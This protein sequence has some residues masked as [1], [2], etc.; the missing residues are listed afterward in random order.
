MNYRVLEWDSRFFDKRVAQITVAGDDDVHRLAECLEDSDAE[1]IYV[2]LP[3]ETAERYRSV[4]EACSGTFYD[5]KVRFGKPVDPALA[6]WDP[7]L[8]E[9]TAESEDL[10]RL[11]YACGYL[12][13]FCLDPGFKP[14]FE[15]L[16]AEW[17]RKS[18]RA[19][20]SRV[21]TL[22]DSRRML[23]MVVTSVKDAIGTMELLAIDPS[24]RGQGL[25]TRLLKQC[26]AYYVSLDARTCTVVTQEANVG[27][28]TLYEK[29]GYRITSAQD[30]WHVWKG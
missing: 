18:L 21:F 16:Y 24:G 17:M 13:R 1:A 4:L 9:T 28:C 7:L 6:A 26:E 19:E 5:R 22:S 2:F 11:A 12:S 8:V 25:A 20:G 15:A 27:A 14:R 3:T 30:V 29:A 23:G 10:L